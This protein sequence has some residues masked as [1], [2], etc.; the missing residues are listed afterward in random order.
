MAQIIEIIGVGNVEFPDGMSKDEMAQALKKLPKPS[1]TTQPESPMRPTPQQIEAMAAQQPASPTV[2]PTKPAPSTQPQGFNVLEA[3]GPAL[4]RQEQARQAKKTEEISFD[5]LY[6][7]PENMNKIVQYATSRFGKSGTP[8]PGES[9]EDYTKRWATHMRMVGTGNLISATQELQYL[10]NATDAEKLKA[11]EAYDLFD[12]TASY[13]S[14]GGQKG[15][16]P[17]FDV[18]GS[19]LSD[20]STAISLGAGK[21]ATSAFMKEAAKTGI[22]QAA[23]TT[24]GR[25][26]AVPAIEATGAA[27]SDVAQQKIELTGEAARLQQLEGILPTLSPEDQAKYAPDVNA[28]R[29]KVEAGVSGARVAT[30]AVLGGALGTAE[31]ALLIKGGKAV[32]GKGATA[33][34]D[35]ILKQRATKFEPAPKVEVSPKDATEKSIEDA[36]DIFEGRNLLNKEGEPTS[37]AEMQ[38]RNDIN[39]TAAKVAKE[40]WTRVPDLAPQ[41][42]QKISDAVKNV[43]MS[44]DKIDNVVLEDSLAKAGITAEEFARMNRTTVGDAGRTLQ[45]YSVLAR[46]QNKLKSIDP[47]AAKEVD[48]MYGKRNALVDAFSGLYS[49]AQRLDRELKALM[50]SQVATT[51]R[52]GIS[53]GNIV[54]FGAA[55]EAIE[56]AL[57]RVGKSAVEVATGKPVTGT[58]TGGMKSVYDDAVRTTFYLGQ[59]GLSSDVTDAL[60]SSSP[61]LRARILKTTGETGTEQLSKLGQYANT[62][63]TA[64]DAFFRKAIFVSNVEKQLNRVGIDMYDILAQNKNVPF[65]VLNN[66][67]DEAL[68]ATMSKM[69]TKGPLY[70]GV[71][72]IE[73]IPIVGSTVIPFPRF[74][75]NALTWTYKHSPMN[76][77]NGS[78]DIARGSS[79]LKQGDDAGNAYLARGLENVSKSAVGTAAIYA[80]YKY[81][82]AHQDTDWFDTEGPDGSRVDIRALWPIG[83]FMAMGD[84]LVKFK[85]KRTDEFKT[86]ELM[87]AVTGF[88]VPAGTYAWLGDKFTEAASK[89]ASSEESDDTKLNTFFGEWAGEYFG[90]ALI[91][92]QQISDIIG[93]IDRDETL[94]RD[95]YQIPKGEEGFGTSLQQQI[96]KRTPVVKQQLPEYQPALRE[97]AAFNDAGPL[98]MLSGIAVKGRPTELEAEVERLNIDFRKVFTGTGDK[99]IDAVARKAMAPL[100]MD[101]F[102]QV[103]NTD[104][105]QT[106]S[107]DGQKIALQNLLGWAQKNA[108]EIATNE[109]M[110]AAF[111]KGDQSRIFAVKYD[112]L[113]AEV[114]RETA[115]FY[116]QNTGQDLA[117]TKD[118]MSAL[119][120]AESIRGVLKFATG[121]L[122]GKVAS[123][124]VGTAMKKSSADLLKEMQEAAL[125]KAAVAEPTTSPVMDQTANML[126][127]NKPVLP[128][129]ATKPMQAPTAAPKEEVLPTTPAK[130]IE[131]PTPSK[132]ADEFD[133]IDYENQ[134]YNEDPTLNMSYSFD[135][136]PTADPTIVGKGVVGVP[137]DKFTSIG[138]P[139]GAINIVRKERTEAF[140][141]LRGDPDFLDFD[142]S[143]LSTALAK[144]RE[145]DSTRL[146]EL[147]NL[148]KERVSP[149]YAPEFDIEKANSDQFNVFFK[150]ANAEQKRLDDLRTR[151][152]GRPP[153]QLFHGQ[154]EGTK[155][156]QNLVKKGFV[157]PQIDPRKHSEMTVGAP[158]FTKDPNLNAL[159]PKFGG[160]DVGAYGA[161]NFPYADYIYRRVNMPAKTYDLANKN[162]GGDPLEAMSL[163][164]RAITGADDNAVPISL[165][166]GYHLESEDMFIEADKLKKM[167]FER[168]ASKKGDVDA[169]EQIT[170]SISEKDLTT[171]NLSKIGDSYEAFKQGVEGKRVSEKDIYKMYNDVRTLFK[172]ELSRSTKVDRDTS[173]VFKREKSSSKGTV[174]V[175]GGAGSRYVNTIR[176]LAEGDELTVPFRDLPRGMSI[177]DV[178]TDLEKEMSKL[179]KRK[180]NT[181]LTEKAA[182]IAE[183]KDLLSGI[184]EQTVNKLGNVTPSSV[185]AVGYSKG[186]IPESKMG[187][188]TSVKDLQE[189]KKK[190]VEKVSRE[191]EEDVIDS[192]RDQIENIDADI[193]AKKEAIGPLHSERSLKDQVMKL[194][195]KFAKGGLATRR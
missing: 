144:Y 135:D 47:V 89:F 140:D 168:P 116:K 53:S 128:K 6:S 180:G 173:N 184:R 48:D 159:L 76:V 156:V 40:I 55:S 188:A 82:E 52:N 157:S 96:M 150:I 27:A 193:A 19:I 110:Q 70:F 125:K 79:M 126:M 109:D 136:L 57:Y 147:M 35:E 100:I 115:I 102:D 69:P 85:N 141:K 117:T 80:A 165:P 93:A 170:K 120:M 72:F 186:K 95:A 26:A 194:T 17:V 148:P 77:F 50:V 61:A 105:Y 49:G 190:L 111:D 195:D 90:R 29:K 16:K 131:A 166:K 65:D 121:G 30:S 86:K 33:E 161:V 83:P 59:Q 192:L 185:K 3:A 179:A 104:Y 108:K 127:G 68:S 160:E 4:M 151:Y 10:N 134:M 113:P 23:K 56:S 32:A 24:A 18:L 71:K 106:A 22:K 5:K 145:K 142:D 172:Q 34:L 162:R 176:T 42:D 87:E 74:M 73:A 67:T 139:D 118:Y 78:V 1:Q 130:E 84:W 9:A 38:I 181:V 103:K 12:K 44:I 178:L 14:E 51:I 41:A 138:G 129:P 54:T 60:L 149:F 97:Q 58:F 175:T 15:I 119:A 155:V 183:M 123:E 189:K 21:I 45:A 31:T 7:D 143:V 152:K 88:K 81:R 20:P 169:R 187:L 37:V 2:A 13:F 66:A 92:A 11:K 63:N 146:S 114:K 94:P 124:I 171:T 107:K 191:W 91:P 98:K 122:A 153:V 154:E 64:Q 158:S 8:E 174:S 43:F 164:N 101:V 28:L 137:I 133:D 182:N 167:G 62:L 46:I 99:V 75:A 163:Y 39:Q 36:Y 177:V 112:K 25:L 132:Q